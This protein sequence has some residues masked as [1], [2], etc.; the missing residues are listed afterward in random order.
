MDTLIAP[1]ERKTFHIVSLGC[2]KNT[3]DS[4]AME[5][6]LLAADDAQLHRRRHRAIAMERGSHVL[7]GEEPVQRAPRLVV[8]DDADERR[9]SGYPPAGRLVFRA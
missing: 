1:T 5:Q 2:A 8:P 6:L 3:V 4:E 9:D 7:A